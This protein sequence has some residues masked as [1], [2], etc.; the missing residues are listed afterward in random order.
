[1]DF[2]IAE[3]NRLLQDSVRSFVEEK[4]NAVWKQ[5]E[6][7]GELPHSLIDGMRELGLFG[8]SIP[9]EYGGLGF[10]VVQKALAHEMMGR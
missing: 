2:S 8:L 1:M 9:P 10:S 6:H 4:A 3:E 7:S 5:I